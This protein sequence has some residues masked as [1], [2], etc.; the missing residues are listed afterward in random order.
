MNRGWQ[1]ESIDGQKGGWSWVSGVAAM[2]AVVTAPTT[3]GCSVVYCSCSCSCSVVE[4]YLW[5][6][7]ISVV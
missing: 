7:V 4:L 2:V 6:S 1:S 5:C 3:A